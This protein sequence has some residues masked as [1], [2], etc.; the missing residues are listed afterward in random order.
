[1]MKQI[2]IITLFLFS[3]FSVSAQS[4]T[5][6]APYI[7]FPLFPPVKLLKPDSA[8]YF[9]KADLPKNKASMVML[10]NPACDH[11]QK[12]TEDITK[13]IEQFK[14]IHI[15]MATMMPFDSMMVFRERYKLSEFK[16]ITVGVDKA[17]FLS[18][19]YMV[20]FL[21]FIALYDK[22][23]KLITQFEGS[24]KLEDILKAFK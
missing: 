18:T 6:A 4:D 8:S 20:R 24:V 21:P 1:M 23:G 10:F 13:N 3:L 17:Y 9:T 19:F 16:N 7:R 14:N 15:V 12:E 11:C 2:L 5:M 22:K